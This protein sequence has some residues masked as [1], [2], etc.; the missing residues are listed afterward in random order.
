V[1]LLLSLPPLPPSSARATSTAAATA[2]RPD[3]GN[4]GASAAVAAPTKAWGRPLPHHR[5]TTAW[6]GMRGDAFVSTAWASVRPPPPLSPP[7]AAPHAN[8]TAA[9]VAAAAAD[10]RGAPGP[11]VARGGV[12]HGLCEGGRG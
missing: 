11:A 12:L 8:T 3:H 7:V 2:P 6:P 1:L 4:V 9:A 10:T 5:G